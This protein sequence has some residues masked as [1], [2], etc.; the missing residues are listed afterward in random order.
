[1]QAAVLTR[2]I[3]S[4]I[5]DVQRE[6]FNPVR[7]ADPDRGLIEEHGLTQEGRAQRVGKERSTVANALRLL[8]LP[9]AV[10]Q[11]IVAG[12]LSMGHAR[13]LLALRAEDARL[14]REGKPRTAGGDARRAVAGQA[15]RSDAAL[16]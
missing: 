7:E 16:C 4:A 15:S 1:V 2:Y 3:R 10:K 13:A 8:R 6:D 9:D 11:S 14:Q 5:I 12:S